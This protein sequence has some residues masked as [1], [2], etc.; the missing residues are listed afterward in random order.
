MSTL[1]AIVAT[2][3]I[4][5]L[6][7][8]RPETYNA[9]KTQHPIAQL[10]Y[11]LNSPLALQFNDFLVFNRE[12][13]HRIQTMGPLDSRQAS[14]RT[15]EGQRVDGDQQVLLW[16]WHEATVRTGKPPIRP[17]SFDALPFTVP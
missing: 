16:L 12:I 13:G 1:T 6:S 17:K 10:Y 5:S 2:L 14:L 8:W 3:A 9:T 15:A 4:V 7:R 11:P